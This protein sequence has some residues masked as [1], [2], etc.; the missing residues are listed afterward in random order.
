ML[1][2]DELL[3]RRCQDND[4]AAFDALF[5]RHL[6]R[7]YALVCHYVGNPEEAR[8]LTQEVFVRVYAHIRSFRGQSAFTTWLYRIAVN[9]C[10]EQ[11]RKAARRRSHAAFVPLDD[12]DRALS[13]EEEG[14]MDSVVRQETRE[15]VQQAVGDLPEAHRL[16]V[17]LRY[18]Q[19]LSCKEIAEILDC[20]VGTVN[21]RLHYAMTK[22]RAALQEQLAEC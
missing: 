10:L 6:N 1:S 20:P 5:H 21:S 22:L 15:R 13:T 2:E 4:E 7:V 3:V 16:V 14:P 9:V 12:V 18:F 19:G 17:S 11:Q 8:D